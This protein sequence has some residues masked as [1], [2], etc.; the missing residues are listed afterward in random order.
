M[1]AFGEW[2]EFHVLPYQGY[3]EKSFNRAMSHGRLAA[4]PLR[5]QSSSHGASCA[6]KTSGPGLAIPPVQ[7]PMQDSLCLALQYRC[8]L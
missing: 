7:S 2:D 3:F 1:L 5:M 8:K 4:A 6:D